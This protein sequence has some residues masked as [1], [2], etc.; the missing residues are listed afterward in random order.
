MKKDYCSFWPD[1][2]H[3]ECCKL[4]DIAYAKGGDWKSRRRADNMLRACVELRS[5]K[6]MAWTM[7]FGVRI[8]GMLPHHFK[9]DIFY[10]KRK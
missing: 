5:G 1:G 10:R 6:F 8:F 4:H 9:R 2:N 7:W 3:G